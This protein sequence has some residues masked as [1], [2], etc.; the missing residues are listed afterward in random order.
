MGC[1]ALLQLLDTNVEASH[2]A[3]HIRSCPVCHRGMVRLSRA[4]LIPN[5]LT[6][7]QC[8]ARFPAY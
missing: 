3:A 8:R 5:V 7:D 1:Q 4:L 2:L 6:C